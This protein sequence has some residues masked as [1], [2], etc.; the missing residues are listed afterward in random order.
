[1]AV[2]LGLDLA[3][4]GAPNRSADPPERAG[5]KF[6]RVDLPLRHDPASGSTC[7]RRAKEWLVTIILLSI[8]MFV[9][10]W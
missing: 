5:P 3:A 1:M 8:P 6:R 10:S 7:A 2:T 9:C 4:L